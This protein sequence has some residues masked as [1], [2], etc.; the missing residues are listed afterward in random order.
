LVAVPKRL[1]DG[2][3]RRGKWIDTAREQAKEGS[4]EKAGTAM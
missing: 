3:G 1:F 4:G 2:N